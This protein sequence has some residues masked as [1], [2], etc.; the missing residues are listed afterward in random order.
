M[1][2]RRFSCTLRAAKFDDDNDGKA[3]ESM[4]RLEE[5]FRYNN[6]DG[7]APGLDG[8]EEHDRSLNDKHQARYGSFL[9]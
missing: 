8:T 6:V 9:L 7:F 4:M 5:W 1:L 3:K 2:D